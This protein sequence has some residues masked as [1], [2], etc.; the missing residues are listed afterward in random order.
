[1]QKI[2]FKKPTLQIGWIILPVDHIVSV[3]CNTSSNHDAI[4]MHASNALLVGKFTK[5]A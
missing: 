3:L 1:M 5:K 2:N 4:S